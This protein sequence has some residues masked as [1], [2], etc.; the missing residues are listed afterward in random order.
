MRAGFLHLS[1]QGGSSP[2][3]R[4]LRHLSFDPF[5]IFPSSHYLEKVTSL[6]VWLGAPHTE[7]VGPWYWRMQELLAFEYV[8]TSVDKKQ[9]SKN[10]IHAAGVSSITI[11]K[12]I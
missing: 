2:P 6:P 11:G 9:V 12:V 4:Q 7:S 1:C 5:V 10:E 8:K 3:A